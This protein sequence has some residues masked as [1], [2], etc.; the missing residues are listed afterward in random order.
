VGVLFLAEAFTGAMGTMRG[1]PVYLS[2][3]HDLSAIALWAAM[4]GLVL[5]SGRLA[6]DGTASFPRIDWRERSR[7]YLTLTKPII[8]LLLL[9]T[10]FAGMV[11]GARLSRLFSDSLGCARV[12]GRAH[13]Q[14]IDRDI[15]RHATHRRPWRR[16]G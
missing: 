13:S 10:T 12:G 15:D 14:Y 5:A 6:G 3:L 11:A 7:D 2:F 1:N 9:V 8:V 16:V 4:L